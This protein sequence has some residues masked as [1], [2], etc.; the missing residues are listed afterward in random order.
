VDLERRL[1][2]L[3][4]DLQSFKKEVSSDLSN[5]KKEVFRRLDKLI[6]ISTVVGVLKED[7]GKLENRVQ[8]L[9]TQTAVVSTRLNGIKENAKDVKEKVWMITGGAWNTIKIGII[10]GVVNAMFWLVRLA[11]SR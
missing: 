9:E 5:F 7:V 6:E 10:V 8:E 3:S 11:L 4:N 2:E 1:E